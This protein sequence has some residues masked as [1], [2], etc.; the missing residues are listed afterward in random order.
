MGTI[1]TT[2]INYPI[3]SK[4]K[5]NTIKFYAKYNKRLHMLEHP[6]YNEDNS[7]HCN[8]PEELLDYIHKWQSDADS[9]TQ[10]YRGQSNPWEIKPSF[11]RDNNDEKNTIQ[12]NFYNTI[13]LDPTILD[14][15][16]ND[17]KKSL[18]APIS[19]HKS[20]NH[21]NITY[22]N[23]K[24]AM[25][26]CVF[27][28]YLLS[29]YFH[30]SNKF[31]LDVNYSNLQKEFLGNETHHR[32]LLMTHKTCSFSPA[33]EQ[34]D[35]YWHFKNE[36]TINCNLCLSKDLQA[37]MSR[38]IIASI[39]QH[40]GCQTRLLDLTKSPLIAAFFASFSRVTTN[41]HCSNNIAIYSMKIV[42]DEKAKISFINA[43]DKKINEFI[44]TQDGLFAYVYGDQY[45]LQ[46]GKWPSIED[47]CMEN[48]NIKLNRLTLPANKSHEL[49][50]KLKNRGIY[51]TK[52][53][54]HYNTVTWELN[55]SLKNP[56]M[57]EKTIFD[58]IT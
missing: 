48:T 37:R 53:M 35:A 42:N 36:L 49:L 15:T 28:Y 47:L 4:Q 46:N 57:T 40:H 34:K 11:Y 58:I 30:W 16:I 29:A 1:K 26:N 33:D 31:R 44:Y 56:K 9:K 20:L 5:H 52:L 3:D 6:Y 18:Q 12:T 13:S 27:E 14:N 43:I 23:V 55:T 17:F 8:S 45:Y 24:N 2:D 19:P 10:F 54:P 25:L 51:A 41:K 50:E 7:H 39:A 22:E 32:P 38:I 21:N